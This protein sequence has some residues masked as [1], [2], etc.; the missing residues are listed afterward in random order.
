MMTGISLEITAV[1]TTKLDFCKCPQLRHK[2]RHKCQRFFLMSKS[3]NRFWKPGDLHERDGNDNELGR[4]GCSR[5][6]HINCPES[7]DTNE[8]RPG[9]EGN[10][11]EKKRAHFWYSS[12]PPK[13]SLILSI[14]QPCRGTTR[15]II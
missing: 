2:G 7:S 13:G 5:A 8:A 14:I 12:P 6:R 9:S 11:Q 3:R 15:Y 1:Q 4:P 10:P